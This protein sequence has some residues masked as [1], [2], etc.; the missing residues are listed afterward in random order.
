MLSIID[1]YVVREVLHAFLAVLIVLLLIS[2][3]HTLVRYLGMVAEGRMGGDVVFLMV[4]LRIPELITILGPL[5]LMLAIMLA[6]GRLYHESEMAA[7]MACGVDYRRLYVPVLVVALPTALLLGWVALYL[8]PAAN[9]LGAEVRHKAAQLAQASLLSAGRFQDMRGGDLVAYAEEL[10]TDSGEM[11]GVF[12]YTASE[13][14]E[15]VTVAQSGRQR[16]VRENNARYL[17]LSSGARYERDNDTLSYSVY[18]Y[19]GLA[20]LLDEDEEPRDRIRRS[21]RSSAELRASPDPQDRAEFE[22]RLATPVAALLLALVAPLMAHAAP[23]SGRFGRVVAAILLYIIYV[24]M[25][26]VGEALLDHEILPIW[27][28]LWWVHALLIGVGIWLM[29]RH[30]FLRLSGKA[31]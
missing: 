28:A 10:D 18:A 3:S 2:L 23:R 27:M 30:P 26:G 5:S 14:T 21:E 24:N 15:A 4:G 22:W 8:S 6:I 16:F 29:S 12:L 13:Q 25:L 20:V 19:E 9:S 31:P 17:D 1:R 7:L 11:R